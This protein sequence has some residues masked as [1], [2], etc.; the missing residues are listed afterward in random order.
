MSSKQYVYPCV[1]HTKMEDD[2]NT[3]SVTSFLLSCFFSQSARF[4]ETKLTSYVTENVKFFV[5]YY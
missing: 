5:L 2:K 1:L 4:N 3:A